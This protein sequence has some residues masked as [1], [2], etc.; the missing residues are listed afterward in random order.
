MNTFREADHPRGGNPNNPGQFAHKTHKEAEC[1]L[2]DSFEPQTTFCSLPIS[3]TKEYYDGDPG[4]DIPLVSFQ[5]EAFDEECR[6]L[7]ET[8]ADAILKPYGA[9]LLSNGEI[10]GDYSKSGDFNEAWNDTNSELR[11][12]WDELNSDDL[13]CSGVIDKYLT[14]AGNNNPEMQWDNHVENTAEDGTRNVTVR[15]T[16]ADPENPTRRIE[17]GTETMEFYDDEDLSDETLREEAEDYLLEKVG[18]PRGAVE[19]IS[20]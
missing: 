15:L 12:N 3:D 19:K 10:I 4:H 13:M 17:V 20:A 7:W 1:S 16:V 11:Q 6:K 14:I 9:T 2:D 18:L 8:K 5:R